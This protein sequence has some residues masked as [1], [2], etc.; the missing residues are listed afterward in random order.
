MFGKLCGWGG[1][2]LFPS[3]A[4]RISDNGPC[5]LRNI[6]HHLQ[7]YNR[8]T[9]LDNQC[10]RMVYGYCVPATGGY[11]KTSIIRQH[12]FY[13]CA[14][15]SGNPLLR[16]SLT[17]SNVSCVRSP[18]QVHIV[19][20]SFDS[21]HIFTVGGNSRA[22]DS[23]CTS[24]ECTGG[25]SWQNLFEQRILDKYTGRGNPAPTPTVS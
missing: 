13:T 1:L 15:A 11:S 9:V 17:E 14:Q 12:I 7:I 8:R 24:I 18:V 4:S 3:I 19:R 16:V 22:T 21:C 2:T 6:L 10:R 20:C 5:D 23:D 25:A